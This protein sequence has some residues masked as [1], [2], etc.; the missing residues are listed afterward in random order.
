[1]HQRGKMKKGSLL[2]FCISGIILQLFFISISA[3]AS[4]DIMQCMK[5]CIKTEGESKKSVCKTK[6]ANLPV[7]SSN[8]NLDCMSIYKECISVC[9]SDTDCKKICKNALMNCVWRIC[10]IKG[11]LT[12]NLYILMQF[13]LSIIDFCTPNFM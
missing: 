12:T 7:N 1:M 11:N 2:I 13:S 3:S 8:Q 5:M 4:V 9:T 6:C 10:A